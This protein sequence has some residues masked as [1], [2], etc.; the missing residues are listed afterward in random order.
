MT[1][2]H[3]VPALL[4]LVSAACSFD[5]QVVEDPAPAPFHVSY[6]PNQGAIHA[7]P[8]WKNGFLLDAQYIGSAPE[9]FDSKEVRVDGPI[10]HGWTIVN[11]E[12]YWVSVGTGEPAIT[13]FGFAQPDRVFLTVD[14]TVYEFC[15]GRDVY[16]PWRIC[17]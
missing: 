13:L 5:A 15:P 11:P 14:A 2:S 9:G 6:N 8:H 17:E 3:L 10:H 7:A 16:A 4:A 12:S 1:K